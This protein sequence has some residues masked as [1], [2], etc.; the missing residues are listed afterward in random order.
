MIFGS[1]AGFGSSFDL[2]SLNGSNGFVVN[3]VVKNGR[4]GIDVGAAGDVNN[5]GVDD[6]IVQG[7]S[8]VFNAGNPSGGFNSEKSFI[9]FGSRAGF[10]ARLNVD[11]IDGINGFVLKGVGNDSI[12]LVGGGGD[13][14]GDGIDD[15]LLGGGLFGR[16]SRVVFGRS[17]DPTAPP[18]VS[19]RPTTIY[20]DA[21]NV[22]VGNAYEAEEPYSGTLTSR[23]DGTDSSS[24]VIAGT[25][26]SDNIWSGRE[27]N[28]I[29]GGRDGADIIGFDASSSE[30]KITVRAGDG[31]DFV[32]GVGT[33]SEQLNIDLGRGYDG[34]WSL[35]TN[36]LITGS[37]N[38]TI[39]VGGGSVTVVTE[40]GDDVV[41]SIDSAAAN[42]IEGTGSINLGDGNNNVWL[43]ENGF[44]F[45][46][47]GSGDDLIGL[48]SGRNNVSAGSGDNIVYM[49][50]ASANSDGKDIATGAGD[51]YI[52]TGS[53]IDRITAGGGFNS[54]YG[55]AGN[56][57]FILQNQA[58]NFL[59]DFEV[60]S[61][62][63]QLFNNSFAAV[64]FENLSFY[65]GSRESGNEAN[66][67]VFAN[68]VGFIEVANT[69]VAELNN[70]ENFF[71][72][73]S[74]I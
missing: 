70:R 47:T 66:A 56:D 23:T 20:V 4:L 68:G 40:G 55:G 30:R 57:L 63:M 50:D 11:N 18:A 5:D 17:E 10:D 48:G 43:K 3:G 2:T 41:Y 19:A 31:D 38:N 36:G 71:E 72:P 13:V 45:V 37:G 34:F 24:D 49:I 65:Q 51:D 42:G 69:T 35:S 73:S 59:G 74:R 7:G 1:D 44:Y 62:R 27:G 64:T 26:G 32:Y 60:G 25:N 67:Y 54:L 8:D 52:Q 61:D 21:N 28:D 39:G 14:S 9:I 29:I 46:G 15:L 58:Y 12:N 16:A 22:V 6:L 33:G 53:G